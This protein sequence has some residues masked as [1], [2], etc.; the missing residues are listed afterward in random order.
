LT[1]R[2]T[3]RPSTGGQR[4]LVINQKLTLR[5]HSLWYVYQ[6]R[7]IHTSETR[8]SGA[9]MVTRTSKQSCKSRRH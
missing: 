3:A 4:G 1:I 8:T 9:F 7:V 5:L 6:L 2:L